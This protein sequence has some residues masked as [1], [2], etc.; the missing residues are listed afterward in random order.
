MMKKIN[1]DT[2]KFTEDDLMTSFNSP[3]EK[4][5]ENNTENQE[6]AS[7]SKK[8]KKVKKLSPRGGERSNKPFGCG[9]F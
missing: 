2:E 3:R 7:S 4:R 5:N 6:I 9:I 1:Y 8:K